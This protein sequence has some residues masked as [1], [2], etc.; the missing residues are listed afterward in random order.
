MTNPTLDKLIVV[1]PRFAR[2]VS[3][4]RDADRSEALDGYILTP[5]GRDVLGRL[6]AGLRGES[7]T[8]AWSLTGPF[9]SGKSAFA[10]FT[11][12]VLTGESWVRQKARAFLAAEDDELFERLFGIGGPLPRK[13]DRLCP[14]LVAGS[15][16]P[17]E[18][19][20]AALYRKR[21]ETA[22]DR[23]KAHATGRLTH[24]HGYRDCR[25]VRGGA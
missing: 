23:R 22:T 18:K 3:L 14:V 15:R 1:S 6:A 12:Q 5:M 10:L 9:G 4:A 17:L 16:E 19:E 2:S 24:H 25:P 20:L 11:A 8:R 21:R 13:A 7:S